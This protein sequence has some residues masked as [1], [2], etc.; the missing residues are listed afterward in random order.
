[1]A[2]RVF[3]ENSTL[4]KALGIDL[5]TYRTYL[6]RSFDDMVREGLSIVA[7]DPASEA[8]TGCLIVSD[9]H[10]HLETTP[11][12]DKR[13]AAL[14]ALTNALCR[15]YGK[16]RSINPGDAVLIDM[17]VVSS[18]ASGQGIY[19]KMR[20]EAQRLAKDRGFRWVVGELS[21]A[22]TQH[23]V[24][25]K[26]GHEKIAEISFDGFEFDGAFPFRSIESSRSIMLAEGEL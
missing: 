13:F 2:T 24:I 26:L 22:S 5:E 7:I 25:G 20:S 16:V 10:N 9:F 8:V 19:Q 1:L 18:A 23:V 12:T 21:S 4:H 14:A 11:G 17:G 6:R 3:I 15:Q